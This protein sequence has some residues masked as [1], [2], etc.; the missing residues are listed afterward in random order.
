MMAK[1]K[2]QHLV[3]VI[4]LLSIA[5]LLIPLLTSCSTA[6]AAPTKEQCRQAILTFVKSTGQD[7][8]WYLDSEGYRGVK[9]VMVTQIGQSVTMGD[10]PNQYPV[11]PVRATV[12]RYNNFALD[13]RTFLINKN[14]FGEWTVPGPIANITPRERRP[15]LIPERKPLFICSANLIAGHKLNKA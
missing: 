14:L 4:V 2:T 3:K 9:D 10:P 12:Y 6:T 7:Y 15:S 8:Q 13:D 5:L 1:R 11:W